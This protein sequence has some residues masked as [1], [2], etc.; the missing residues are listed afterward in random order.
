MRKFWRLLRPQPKSDPNTLHV[1]FN[2]EEVGVGYVVR[3]GTPDGVIISHHATFQQA[4]YYAKAKALSERGVVVV[5]G[6][7]GSPTSFSYERH[8]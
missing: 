8:L 4:V 7:S 2:T 1:V 5:W 6:P 3:R